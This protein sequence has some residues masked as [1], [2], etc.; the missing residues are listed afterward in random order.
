M[1]IGKLAPAQNRNPNKNEL[2]LVEGDSAGG[3]AKMGRARSFQAILSLKG[4]IINAEKS[5]LATLLKNPEINMITNAIGGGIGEHFDLDDVNYDKIIIMT[6]ADVDGAHIQ[7]LLLTFF[8]RYMKP[9]M[10]AQKIYL[11]LPPLYKISN[12]KS[13]EISYA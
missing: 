13:N 4:K 2:F 10:A 11:A 5:N 6:D 3:T 12:K 9:L 8:Y 7:I 1:L